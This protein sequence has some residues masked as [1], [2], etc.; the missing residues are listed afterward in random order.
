MQKGKTRTPDL[1]SA[2]KNGLFA[3]LISLAVGTKSETV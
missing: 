1:H 3:A 2:I